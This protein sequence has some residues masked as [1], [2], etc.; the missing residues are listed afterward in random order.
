LYKN[1]VNATLPYGANVFGQTVSSQTSGS[2]GDFQLIQRNKM[3]TEITNASWATGYNYFVLNATGTAW[4]T[5][6]NETFGITG[7]RDADNNG[8]SCTVGQQG[9]VRWEPAEETGTTK[10][11]MLTIETT[12]VGGGGGGTAATSTVSLGDFMFVWDIIGFVGMMGFL[13]YLVFAK[14]V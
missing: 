13:G 6:G 14:Y 11:P 10:D 7:D 2:A 12:P 1:G 4:L 5:A 8:P 9:F 3:S